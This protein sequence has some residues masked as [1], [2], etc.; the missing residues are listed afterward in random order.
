[1]SGVEHGKAYSTLNISGVTLRMS[2]TPSDDQTK[3]AVHGSE[4]ILQ[5][6][7][8]KKTADNLFRSKVIR[9]AT[10]GPTAYITVDIG[11]PLV[12][13]MGRRL[14]KATKLRVGKMFWVQFSPNAVKPIRG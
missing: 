13:T 5:R 10:T 2:K 7:K 6:K 1:V 3:I 8:P 14:Y 12:L 4:V 11:V 9:H